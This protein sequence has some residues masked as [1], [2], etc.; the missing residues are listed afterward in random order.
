VRAKAR[1]AC[2][3]KA[4]PPEGTTKKQEEKTPTT[5]EKEERHVNL[6]EPKRPKTMN[7]IKRT[8]RGLGSSQSS[9]KRVYVTAAL[10]LA[11]SMMPIMQAR[12]YITLFFI[13]IFL[14]WLVFFL[15]S[16]AN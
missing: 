9:E 1:R 6:L 2:W 4:R 12:R 13:F 3:N 11:L 5:K 10:A 14:S 15:V 16:I 7:P 8:R